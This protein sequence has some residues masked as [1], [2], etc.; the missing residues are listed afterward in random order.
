MNTLTTRTAYA[1]ARVIGACLSIA[2]LSSAALADTSGV[3][4]PKPPKFDKGNAKKYGKQLAD[5]TRALDRGW[6]DSY[7]KSRMI[8]T[9]AGGDKVERDTSQMIL[10]GADGNKSLARFM[11]PADIRGVSALTHEHPKATD[12][13][14]LYLPAS[15]R[16]RRISGANRT[17]SFQG[18]EFTYEDLSTVEPLRYSWKFLKDG[19]LK[20]DGKSVAVAQLEAIPNY[21]DT[22]YSKLTVYLNPKN[23]R[24]EK[25]DFYDKAGRLLKTLTFS[26]WKLFH[27]RYWRAQLMDMKNHQTRKGTSIKTKSMFINLSLYKRKDGSSRPNLQEAQFTRRALENG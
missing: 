11:S 19:T 17:A 24:V 5:H 10:E 18:T 22:G 8:L 2:L 3:P 7:A 27:G 21:K 25:M 13:S 20:S 14:W 1:H 16:V 4:A 15:R 9:D 6:V 12:D 26:K 23:W